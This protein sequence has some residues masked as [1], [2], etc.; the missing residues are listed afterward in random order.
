MSN[1]FRISLKPRAQLITQRRSE[2]PFP[3]RDKLNTLLKELEKHNIIKQIASSPQE[4][5]D[6]GTTYLYPIF[7]IPKENYIKC[8]VDARHPNS[9]TEQSDE[10]WPIETLASN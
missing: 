2:V 4:K 7:E 5:P 10:S 3:Y 6:C 1:T 9:N 8:V